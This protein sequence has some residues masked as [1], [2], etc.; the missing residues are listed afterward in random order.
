MFVYL[1]ADEIERLI[2]LFECADIEFE[3]QKV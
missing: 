1:Y 3:M 2:A